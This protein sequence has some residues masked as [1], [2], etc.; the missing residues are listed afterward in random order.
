[1]LSKRFTP[2][3]PGS[4]WRPARRA[5]PSSILSM[6]RSS[7]AIQLAV[8]GRLVMDGEQSL[9]R[10]PVRLDLARQSIDISR[11][12]ADHFPSHPSNVRC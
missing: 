3:V 4:L 2:S 8:T 1:V 10:L 6:W 11:I 7:W 5:R 12:A 9:C